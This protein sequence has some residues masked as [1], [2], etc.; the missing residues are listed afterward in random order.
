MLDEISRIDLSKMN[1]MEQMRS[2]VLLLMNT[3][4]TMSARITALEK[5]NQELKDTINRLKGEQGSPKFDGSG[6]KPKR[7]EPAG[8]G[9]AEWT[10]VCSL[11]DMLA[12]GLRWRLPSR[13]A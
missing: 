11:Q 2:I 1:T 4:D 13:R 8:T 6:K 7:D 3:V 10:P 5:E 9:S 12:H